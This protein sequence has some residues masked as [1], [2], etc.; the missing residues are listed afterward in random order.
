[1]LNLR[2]MTPSAKERNPSNDGH[3]MLERGPHEGEHESFQQNMSVPNKPSREA[4]VACVV[5]S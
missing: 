5:P 1:M 4:Y 3:V 2:V